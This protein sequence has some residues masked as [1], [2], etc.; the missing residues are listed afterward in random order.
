MKFQLS[1]LDHLLKQR[2]AIGAYAIALPICYALFV[3]PVFSSSK[4]ICQEFVQTTE[5]P[6]STSQVIIVQSTGGIHADITACQRT[7]NQWRSV[8]T[9]SMKAVVGRHGIIKKEKKTEGDLKTPAGLYPIGEAFGTRPL[10]L[11]M[12]YRYITKDDK[13]VDDV[14]SPQYN[15]WVTGPTQAKSYENMLIEPYK[16]GAVIN[17]NMNPIIPGKG[18]AI[19]MHLWDSPNTPTAGCVAMDEK[20]I[21]KILYWLDKKQQPSMYI[22]GVD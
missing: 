19:F 3:V 10:A 13:F 5:I 15:T 14:A 12:D 16:M 17:Y 20:S 2:G 22:K 9:Q 1:K 4:N 7:K 18:S 21:S 8:F 11:R 6:V